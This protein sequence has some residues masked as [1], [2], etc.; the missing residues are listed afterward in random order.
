MITELS[1]GRMHQKKI[2]DYFLAPSSGDAVASNSAAA[3]L[4][5]LCV[6]SSVT[7]RT[8]VSVACSLCIPYA[9]ILQGC[10]RLRCASAMLELSL[11]EHD[12]ISQLLLC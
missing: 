5:A 8:R 2:T 3:K 7:A 6:V 1:L 4:Y 12:N 9:V 10:R 11:S